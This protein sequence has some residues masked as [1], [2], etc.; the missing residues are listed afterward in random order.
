MAQCKG[1]WK[2]TVVRDDTGAAYD[3]GVLEITNEDGN[4]N[5]QGNHHGGLKNGRCVNGHIAYRIDGPN[6]SFC[7][8]A[9]NI[10]GDLIT[11]RK[12]CQNPHGG[13]G[14]DGDWTAEKGGG[15]GDDDKVD[16]ENRTARRK[17]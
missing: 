15:G 10:Q 16:P 12:R 3:D 1:S 8:Y 5:I 14:A 17:P 6:Q 13:D 7:D 9:G 11:G 4:G 2:S